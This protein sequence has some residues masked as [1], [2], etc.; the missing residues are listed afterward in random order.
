M[1]YRQVSLHVPAENMSDFCAITIN[2]SMVAIIEN[3]ELS[4]IPVR[5]YVVM[6]HWSGSS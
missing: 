3:E 4:R 6:Q 2:F 5:V 1:Y